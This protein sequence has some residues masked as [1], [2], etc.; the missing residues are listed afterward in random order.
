MKKIIS[1]VAA[2]LIG[3]AANAQDI[4]AGAALDYGYPHSGDTQ[5]VASLI[6]GIGLGPWYGAEVEIGGRIAGDADYGTQRL[7]AWGTYDLGAVKARFAG[8]LTSYD[9]GDSEAD[10]YNL[11][12]GVERNFS[13]KVTL[14][15]EFIRD[16]MDDTFTAAV[17]TTRVA[18]LYNF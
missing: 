4:Y 3:S 14:R 6:A 7:R 10:G 9:L 2:G 11:G 8:G 1:I 15:G 18:V 16:F 5:T 17:T 12:V 13:D